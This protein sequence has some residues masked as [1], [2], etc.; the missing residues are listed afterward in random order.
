MAKKIAI[1]YYSMY[2]HI[3]KMAD[4]EAEG[5]REAGL[6]VDLYQIPETLSEEILGKMYAPPKPSDP[7]A[8]ANTLT[9][10]DAFIFGVPTRYGNFPA[11]WKTFWDSTGQLWMKQA[12]AGKMFGTFVSTGTPGG[13]QELTAFQSLSVAIHQ[14]MVYVPLGYQISD[15][16]NL[17]EVHGGSPWGAGTFAGGDG[18]RQPTPLELRVAKGQ[19]KLFAEYI[20]KH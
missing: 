12:L 10:Y 17:D 2:G 8:S 3:K 19:G 16:T 18:S 7:V 4:A 9:E 13:G 6:E 15:I 11:Q 20:A 1:I 14:G 5:V